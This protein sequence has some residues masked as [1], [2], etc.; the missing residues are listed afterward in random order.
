MNMDNAENRKSPL[1]AHVIFRLGTGGLENG[2]VNLINHLPA[3]K[4]RHAVI[5][6]TDYTQFRQRI[7]RDDV[8]IY[9]LHKKEGKDFP[10]YFKL[11]KLFL[12]IK[13]DV[14]HTRNLSALEAQLPGY[15]AG[16]KCRV[17]GE[18]G[19]DVE[20]VDG[21]NPKH[22]LL[23]R[24]FRVLVQ[25]YIPMSKNLEHWLIQQIRV[26]PNKI[27]QIYNGV[28]TVKFRPAGQINSTL[29]PESF[30]RDGLTIIGTV[31]RQEQIKDPMTLLQA[32]IH[33]TKNNPETAENARLV[34]V[35]H[36]R[37]HT[38]LL[39]TASEAGMAERVWFAGDRSDVAELM[40][41]FDIFVLPSI[42]EGISNTILE[43]MATGLP[44]IA[45]RVG[46]NPELVVHQQS[47]YLVES[48]DP[49][50]MAEAI[51]F[52]TENPEIAQKHGAFG[53][54]IC[55]ERFSLERMVKDY[56]DIYDELLKAYG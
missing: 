28:D 8:D 35:G 29:L 36:G 47:G 49:Q 33:W 16:I 42:N 45:T 50:A 38:L 34:F 7:R 53:R 19:R 5:C 1:I 22:T 41:A 10:I 15:L 17:H 14:L 52:Y 4:Y 21:K 12:Q 43:A 31:G 46:G 37:L 25:R 56:A 2:L 39:E 48:Q 55:L 26:S 27:S 11:W 24:C 9:C 32:F 40:Q 51:K 3:Q 23:R 20:D 44:I 6:M 18:H 54:K 30:R 13:P